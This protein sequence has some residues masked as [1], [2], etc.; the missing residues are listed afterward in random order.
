[1]KEKANKELELAGHYFEKIGMHRHAAQCYC[2]ASK[3]EKAAH[4]F[5][6]LVDYG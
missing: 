2:S 5:E 4:M 3:L 1:M 6:S